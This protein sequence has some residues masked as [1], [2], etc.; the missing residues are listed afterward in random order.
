LFENEDLTYR[1]GRLLIIGILTII[2]ECK[3]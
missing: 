1:T 2:F 3:F